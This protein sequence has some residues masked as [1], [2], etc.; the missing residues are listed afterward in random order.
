MSRP[1][2]FQ[3]FEVYFRD[4]PEP[5]VAHTNALDWRGVQLDANAPTP[6]DAIF[7]VCHTALL[8]AGAEGVPRHYDRFCEQLDGIPEQVDAGDPEALDPTRPAP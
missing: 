6:L 7:R 1:T 8:R 4:I 2:P 5:L 3:S